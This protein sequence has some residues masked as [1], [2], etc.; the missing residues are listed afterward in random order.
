MRRRVLELDAVRGLAAL[1]ILVYHFYTRRLPFGWAAV[2][3]FFVLSGYLITSLVLA[4]RESEDFLLRFYVRRGLRIWPIYYLSLLALLVLGPVLPRPSSMAGLP[5]YLTYTQNVTLCW[6]VRAAEFSWYF[7]HTW[8]LAIEEQFYLLW[9]ALILLAGRKR[10]VPL[11]LA[12]LATSVAARW[13]GYHWWTLAGRGDGFAFGGLLAAL[14]CDADR[15]G[16]H[17]VEIS[18]GLAALATAALAYLAVVQ[19]RGGLPDHGMPLWPATTVLA[20]NLAAF[21]LVA[22]VVLHAGHPAL[23][24]LRGRVL[25]YL[26][27]ISYGLYL[28][29]MII[30]RIKLDLAQR[31]RIGHNFWVDALTLAASVAAAALSWHFIER[32]ILALKARFEFDPASSTG[33]SATRA[34]SRVDPAH[35][36]PEGP[37]RHAPATRPLGDRVA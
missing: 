23:R 28:Y 18:R 32:P 9:P 25:G 11:A 4:H 37:D 2:D 10:L 15:V 14:M 12:L 27:Q 3:L 21:A 1:A 16:R 7:K 33:R 8:T 30:L 26:G 6:S 5:S 31:F 19:A 22:G 29:H 34:G 20:I 35:R 24:I 13:Q 17:R 36:V